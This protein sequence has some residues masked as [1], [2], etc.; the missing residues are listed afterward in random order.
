MHIKRENL[1]RAWQEMCNSISSQVKFLKNDP[2]ND[3]H[4]EDKLMA[5][6]WTGVIC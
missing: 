4:F 5:A 2:P 3:E 6:K 1:I